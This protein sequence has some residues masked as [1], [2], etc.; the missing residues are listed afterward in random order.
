MVR[1]FKKNDWL[2][3]VSIDGPQE[4]HDRYRRNKQ[5]QPS[6]VKVMKGI[7]LLNKYGV[8]WNAMAVVNNLNADYPLEFYNFFKEIGCRY[9]QFTPIVE[10]I[11]RHNDGRLLATI[12][13]DTP[14][15]M[16]FSVTP[17]QW[18]NFLCTIFEEWVHNDVGEYYIQL[19]D[20][21]L[22]NWVGENPGICTMGKTCGHAGVMEFN[23]DVYSCD[24]FVFPQYKLG[25]IYSKTLIEMFMER[26]NWNLD[27]TSIGLYQD[28]VKTVNS[29]LLVMVNVQRTGFVKLNWVSLG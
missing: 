18:G 29:Y 3:G 9:I 17:E 25:N 23:G 26:S 19:F 24:H 10:R 22:A 11:F 6:F 16:E 21:T 13:E 12:G 2:V 4:F 28:N 14:E 27:K 20:A 8:D 5:G 1:I 15:L 7:H